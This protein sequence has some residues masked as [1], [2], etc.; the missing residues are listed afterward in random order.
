VQEV[1]FKMHDDGTVEM[2]DGIKTTRINI[3]KAVGRLL[4]QASDQSKESLDRSD[5]VFKELNKAVNRIVSR[6]SRRRNVS[7]D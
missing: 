2:F 1:G 7:P 5:M 4:K 6:K 3:D